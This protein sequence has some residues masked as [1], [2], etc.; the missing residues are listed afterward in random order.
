MNTERMTDT[1]KFAPLLLVLFALVVA[2]GLITEFLIKS[3]L[4]Q[5]TN[6]LLSDLVVGKNFLNIKVAGAFL[7]VIALWGISRKWPRVALLTTLAF[8]VCYTGILIWNI[9]VFTIG[10]L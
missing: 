4:G 3:G 7:A 10:Q 6:P 1:R 5:E 2:D 9:A 8:M